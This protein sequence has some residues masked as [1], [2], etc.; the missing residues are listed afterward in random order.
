MSRILTGLVAAASIALFAVPATAH[1]VE[2]D[3]RIAEASP[4]DKLLGKYKVHLDAETQAQLDE[5]R[6][7]AGD[8]AEAEQEMANA[9]LEMMEAMS[10]ITVE[11]SKDTMT[12]AFGDQSES[13]KF[14]VVSAEADTIK[15]KTEGT[16]N[17]PE[18]SKSFTIKLTATG[19]E[20]S[21]EG[22][23]QVLTFKRQ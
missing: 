13:V 21:K 20:M 14:A 1:H 15:L 9:M 12:M 8:V 11:F 7:K 17:A 16:K 3:E 22:D 4:V 23:P 18:G 2:A 6:K 5:A 19:I 10:K